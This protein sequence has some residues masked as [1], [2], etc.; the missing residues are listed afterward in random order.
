[1]SGTS[2]PSSASTAGPNSVA[3]IH[4]KEKRSL[5]MSRIRSSD[6]WPELAVRKLLFSMGYR[7]RLHPKDLPGKPD[8][9]FPKK[10][11]AIFV[12]GCFWHSHGCKRGQPP[13]SRLEYWLPKLENNKKR[14]TQTIA[15]LETMGWKTLIVWQCQIKD[16]SMLR[17]TLK[18]FLDD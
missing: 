8:I 12:H 7:Y 5:I 9:V 4:T 18:L 14:D 13:K 1:M 3:D 11:K 16:I 2:S 6:T 15:A 17:T 10:K